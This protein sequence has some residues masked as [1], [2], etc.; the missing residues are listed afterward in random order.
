M[1]IALLILLLAPLLTFGAVVKTYT[2]STD[3]TG[4]EVALP[5]LC[6]EIMDSGAVTGY[7]GLRRIGDTIE[8]QGD[9]ISNATL[10]DT[11]VQDHDTLESYKQSKRDDI[12]TKTVK[13][14]EALTFTWESKQFKLNNAYQ[15]KWVNIYTFSGNGLI[16]YPKVISDTNGL[17]H[18]LD[19]HA[20]VVSFVGAGLATAEAFY[21]G[22]DGYFTAI[23]AATTKA[24]VDAVV[25]TR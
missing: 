19:D 14:E 2:I 22:D 3:V 10:L 7:T 20:D 9:S 11:T 6:D 12:I 15:D 5:Y 24:E 1:K 18:N 13:L 8:V 25:D 4:G 17:T 16:A 23:D 21:A